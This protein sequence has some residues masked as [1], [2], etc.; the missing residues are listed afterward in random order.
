LLVTCPI[1][2]PSDHE[3]TRFRLAADLDGFGLCRALHDRGWSRAGLQRALG[4]EPDIVAR[5]A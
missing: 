2:R 5:A 3:G 1:P 4:I